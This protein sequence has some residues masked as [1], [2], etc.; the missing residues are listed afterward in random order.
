MPAK[1]EQRKTT[2][3]IVADTLRARIVRSEL[4]AGTRLSV[5]EIALEL[6]VSQTPAREA[7]QLLEGEGIVR[8][9]A[10]R[11]GRV[12]DLDLDDCEEI[13]VMRA[14]LEGFASKLGTDM[15]TA[16]DL[17]AMATLL[18]G[19]R[20]AARDHDIDLF[21]ERDRSFHQVH[22]SAAGRETLWRKI[23]SLRRVSERYTRAIYHP[24]FGG[25]DWTV[26]SHA[27]LFALVEA[28][29]SAEA[30]EF[31][32]QDLLKTHVALR[33]LLQADLAQ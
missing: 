22:Y 2:R 26:E 7:L 13:Y 32:K 30:E 3:D 33:E 19:M 14:A 27:E 11:G 20:E 17:E 9:D 25:M 1:P 24:P 21:I 29:K 10:F 6:G 4:A 12:A 15:I 8:I 18:E 5:P 28:R 31:T 23:L 16:A